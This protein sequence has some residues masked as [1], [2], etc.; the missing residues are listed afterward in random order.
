MRTTYKKCLTQSRWQV[1]GYYQ[2][3]KCGHKY[4]PTYKEV[5][6]AMHMGRTRYLKCPCC[7]QKSWNKKVIN[8]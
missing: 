6:M 8:K 5:K 2:C 3:K 7:K 4:I 1:A